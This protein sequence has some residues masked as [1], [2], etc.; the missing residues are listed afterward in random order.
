MWSVAMLLYVIVRG[1]LPFTGAK[2]QTNADPEQA[3]RDRCEMVSFLIGSLGPALP[4]SL[5]GQEKTEQRR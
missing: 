5:P 4:R 1:A 3:E 2:A